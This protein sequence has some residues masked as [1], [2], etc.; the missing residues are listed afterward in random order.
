LVDDVRDLR[1]LCLT[2]DLGS[3]TAAAEVLGESKSTVSRRISRLERALE[4]RLLRRSRRRVEATEDG[5]AY[6]ERLGGVLEQLAEANACARR[7]NAEPSG[8]LRVGSPFALAVTRLARPVA[9]F[10]QR[11]PSIEVEMLLGGRALDFDRDRLDLAFR[12][13]AGLEDSDLVAHGLQLIEIIAVASPDYVSKHGAPRE[14]RELADHRLALVWPGRGPHLVKW[15]RGARRGA[16]QELSLRSTLTGTDP[17]FN[18]ELAAVGACI[19]IVPEL[20]VEHDL[21]EGR[22]LRLL[23]DF[24]GPRVTLY[25]LHRGGRFLEPKVRAFRDFMLDEF[26]AAHRPRASARRTTSSR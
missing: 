25:L 4:V 22:L 7:A 14:P 10:A 18:R 12:P 16:V 6:R 21:A 2:V 11:F 20:T 26:G 5:R 17:A 3:L 8:H 9:A 15:R 13:S 24:E 19:A 23:P 1:A